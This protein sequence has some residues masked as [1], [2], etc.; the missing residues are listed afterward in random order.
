MS[1]GMFDSLREGLYTVIIP[2][3]E[4]LKVT[5]KYH[6][7]KG[8]SSAGKCVGA[9]DKGRL[10]AVVVW[11]NPLSEAVRSQICGEEYKHLVV[12]L[13]RLCLVPDC[14][15]PASQIVSQSIKTLNDWQRHNEYGEFKILIS[16]ADSRVGH[17]G[18]V[19]QSMS[20]LYCGQSHQGNDGKIRVDENGHI[21]A[22]RNDGVNISDAEALKRGW[23]IVSIPKT[24]K[25][26]YVKFVGSKSEKK[27]LRKLL[28]L[29]VLPYPKPD[30]EGV[31][32]SSSSD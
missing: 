23:K 32:G 21:R 7:L 8:V 4:A 14:P 22:R 1:L 6:Y 17:H 28:Q 15:F 27:R 24:H 19:Y 16:F 9:Y 31:N 30:E 10:V 26:R 13:Q 20:W 25:Y 12:E 29:D 3:A 18:G 2:R 5:E 11:A